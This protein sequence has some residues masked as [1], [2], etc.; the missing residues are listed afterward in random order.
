MGTTAAR[1]AKMILQNTQDVLADELLTA[2]QAIDIRRRLNTHGQG[3]TRCT[4]PS[5]STSA[6]KSRSTK[7]TARSGPTSARWRR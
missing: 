4:K 1:K 7:W 3:L 5:T 6:R 2:C